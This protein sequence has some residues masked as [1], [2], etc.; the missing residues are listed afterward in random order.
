VANADHA[1]YDS[2]K[3]GKNTVRIFGKD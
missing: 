2:K 1:L 3:A